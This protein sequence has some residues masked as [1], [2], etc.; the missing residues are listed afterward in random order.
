MSMPKDSE[1]E[2]NLD[3]IRSVA[4]DFAEKTSMNYSDLFSEASYEYLRAIKRFDAS[5][6]VKFTSF[7]VT[8]MRNM[9]INFCK[10]HTKIKNRFL[11]EAQWPNDFDPSEPERPVDIF[12]IIENWPDDARFVIRMIL[13][14]PEMYMAA[15]PNFRRNRVGQKKRLKKVKADLKKIG[16]EEE[17]IER[18][19]NSIQ[20]HLNA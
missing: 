1:P 8:H 3:L 7:A 6:S 14:K 18:T 11:N 9:L 16:W 15:T 10:K 2:K 5:H 17:R 19:I 20:D 13:Q 12:D 4:W